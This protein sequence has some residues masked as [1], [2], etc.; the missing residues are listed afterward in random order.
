MKIGDKVRFLSETGGGKVA[1]FRGKNIVLVEDSDGFEIPFPVNE[2]VVV[3]E[4]DYSTKRV[5][6]VKSEKKEIDNR[7]VRERLRD[8]EAAEAEEDDPS[9]GFTA[10]VVER[11][12]GD[13]LSAYLAFVP[14]DIKEISNTRFEAYIVNDSN[15]YIYYSYLSAEG[16]SW[17]VRSI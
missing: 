3:N 5:V 4:E 8:N 12:G 7:S 17:K 2:V 9:E 1:G 10:P 16:A 6:E 15:Y 11:K 13:L 14:I